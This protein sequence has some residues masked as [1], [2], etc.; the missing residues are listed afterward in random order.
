MNFEEF[1]NKT[2]QTINSN[3]TDEFLLSH[4]SKFNR[5][6]LLLKLLKN[7]SLYLKNFDFKN[8][9]IF[10][11]NNPFILIEGRKF[12]LEYIFYLNKSGKPQISEIH[13]TLSFFKKYK[14]Y[15]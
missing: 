6:S 8:D 11:D 12:R 7:I 10:Q 15:P 2:N 9:I 1:I 13:N 4:E 3:K 5:A 14:L